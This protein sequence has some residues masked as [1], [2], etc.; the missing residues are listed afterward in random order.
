MEPRRIQAS[1]FKTQ[2]LAI[3]DQ[4]EAT[5]ISVI[6]TKHGHPVAQLA[7]LDEPVHASTM[8][9][10]RLVAEDD[11]VYFSSGEAWEAE[12]YT[13]YRRSA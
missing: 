4:V 10:V 8:G 2:C 1:T 7:P 6:V 12:L 9:S 13:E 3:L 11:Q 5:K